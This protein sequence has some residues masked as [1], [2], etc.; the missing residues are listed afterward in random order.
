[1]RTVQLGIV[2]LGAATVIFAADSKRE[3]TLQRGIDLLESKGDLA[4]A[5]PLFEEAS[6][7]S[8]KA[9]AARA[10]LYVGQTQ[11][12]QGADKARATYE[13]ILKE[14]S[15]QTETTAIAQ[16]RL[17]ALGETRVPGLLSN[18]LLCDACGGDSLASLS[19]DG[20]LM[21]STD[22]AITGDLVLRDMNSRQERRL[23]VATSKDFNAYAEWPLL[24]RDGKQAIYNYW[25][26][27]G[28]F[29]LRIVQ[30]EPGSKPRS[31]ADTC[32]RN[33]CAPN[34]WFPDGKSVLINIR[35]QS[36]KTWQLARVSISDGTLAP[37]KLLVWREPGRAQVSPDGKYIVYSAPAE[38]PKQAPGPGPNNSKNWHIWVVAADG[39]GE[40]EIVKTAGLNRHP[41]WTADGKHVLFVSDRSGDFDLWSIAV[42]DGKAQGEASEVRP[43]MGDVQALGLRGG[44]YY[45]IN[46]TQNKEVIR[47]LDAANPNAR[48]SETFVGKGPAWSPD[49]KSVAFKRRHPG[50]VLGRAAPLN[51]FD[52]V[53]HSLETGEEKVYPSSVGFVGEYAPTWSHDSQTLLT[54]LHDSSGMKGG[55]RLDLRTG[56]WTLVTR[57]GWG[58]PVLSPDDKTLYSV[59]NSSGP[60]PD[61][62]SSTDLATGQERQILALPTAGRTNGIN[63]ALSP[64][65]RTLAF[66]WMQDLL[67]GPQRTLHIGTVSVDGSNFREVFAGTDTLS[68]GGSLVWSKDGHSIF[69][70]QEQP[71]RGPQWAIMQVAA[72]GSRPASVFRSASSSNGN[73]F[74]LSPDG[75]RLVLGLTEARTGEVW[76][77]DNV[78]SVVR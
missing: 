71:D 28:G 5:M 11:E 61:H 67:F 19:S 55:Y 13:R 38:S 25:D 57:S 69:F 42:Q 36:D 9:L 65:G 6:H 47:I 70:N 72:D 31:L 35:D 27:Q 54:G 12:R 7:S 77:L 68:G 1:M 33:N 23:L 60:M 34:D 4:K 8:D 49:G 48:A 74:D 15:S 46:P 43:K 26:R 41:F 37:I 58:L 44:S 50:G 39:S 59:G 14:F 62:I 76:A 30:T 18:R 78:L 17:A 24:S 52:L 75:S 22:W 73:S 56:A 63:L 10:L 64:D 51:D 29:D 21:L 32:K 16:R 3:Q 66:S 53:V 45:Y 40:N 2:V 20:R